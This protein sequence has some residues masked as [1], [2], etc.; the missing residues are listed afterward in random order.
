MFPARHGMVID[1][2]S[3]RRLPP[4]KGRKFHPDLARFAPDGRFVS[5]DNHD[6][7]H[8]WGL[9]D[10]RT[11]KYFTVKED[12]YSLPWPSHSPEAS[13]DNLPGIRLVAAARW[14]RYER[15]DETKLR[16]V[17]AATRLDMPPDL[18]EL[19][20]QVA[21]RGE[22]GE[23]GTFV[24]WDEP[25]WERKRQEL[26][27]QPVPW[28]AFPFPGH[29]AADRLH[30][31]R[32]KFLATDDEVAEK[33]RLLDELIRRAEEIGDKNEATRWRA[34]RAKQPEPAPPPSP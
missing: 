18:L 2:R 16:W 12:C 15:W 17:P 4:P 9:I 3:G 14:E 27:A 6:A 7:G 21:V 32:A 20:A 28:P 23:D 13:L 33:R 25:T 19:W 29:V 24:K 11:E 34:E 8:R 1:A 10:T 5:V 30:W 26:A 31:L 22:I